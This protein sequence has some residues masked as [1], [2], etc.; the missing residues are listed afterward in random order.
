[1]SFVV[2]IPRDSALFRRRRC[3]YLAQEIINEPFYLP[4]VYEGEELEF[5]ARFERSGYTHRMAVL[6]GEMTVTLEPDESGGY[7]ALIQGL[8][9]QKLPDTA[10]LRAIAERLQK[11]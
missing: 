4:I 7:R 1:M 3:V 5:K 8:K 10:L 9:D 2:E 6:I 11:L